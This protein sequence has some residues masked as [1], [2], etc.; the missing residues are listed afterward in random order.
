MDLIII[1]LYAAIQA[2]TPLLIAGLGELVVEKSGT[3]N[4]GIEGMMLMGCVAGFV[5]TIAFGSLLMGIVMAMF[6]GMMMA[7][8]FACLTVFLRTNQVAT[9]LALTLFGIGLSTF[10]GLD[11][12]GKPLQGMEAIAIPIFADIPVLGKLLFNQDLITYS[13]FVLLA[14][15]WWFLFRTRAGLILRAVGENH[16]AAFAMGYAVLK[17]K[18]AAIL[19]G[20]I[21]AGLAGAYLSLAYTP[22]WTQQM[23]AGKGWIVLALVVFSGWRPIRLV[24]GAFLFGLV[25]ILQLFM[26]TYSGWLSWIP[27]EFFSMLPYLITIIVLV[28]MQSS[29]KIK[30]S[31]V[32]RSHQFSQR[33]VHAPPGCLGLPFDPR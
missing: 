28:L 9:G 12:E 2:M 17:V 22:L 19:F 8:I 14:S 30:R 3:L 26:Q 33:R 24:L 23:T 4:L 29:Q 15:V 18:I 32:E 27:T 20:G 6:A 16:H 1:I 7:L 31:R 25:S 10:I 13:S 21:L 5:A 11:Y